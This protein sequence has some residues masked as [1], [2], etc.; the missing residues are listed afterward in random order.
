MPVDTNPYAFIPFFLDAESIRNF[1]GEFMRTPV[2]T[3][4]LPFWLYLVVFL[5]LQAYS[6]FK[7]EVRFVEVTI[8]GIFAFIAVQYNRATAIFMMM[9]I[10][11]VARWLTLLIDKLLTGKERLKSTFLPAVCG[12]MILLVLAWKF[13]PALSGQYKFSGGIDQRVYPVGSARFVNAVNPEGNLYNSQKFGA[14]LA[15]NLSPDNKIF[16]YNLPAIF[17]DMYSFVH[18]PNEREGWNINYAIVGE[19]IET[20]RVFTPNNWAPVYWEPNA[21]VLLKRTPEN[22]KLLQEYEL[23]LFMPHITEQQF[24]SHYLN[25]FA[26]RRLAKETSVY[27]SFR[28]DYRMSRL[29]S[30]LIVRPGLGLSKSGRLAMVLSA[31][32]YNQESLELQGAL[33]KIKGN[34]NRS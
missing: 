14:Y 26:A 6:I 31:L 9:S 5:A 10:P 3:F 21:I 2:N 23:H 17:R 30:E 19:R 32:K 12:V 24:R 11:F 22:L 28:E 4:F 16:H 7:K 8:L 20:E 15:Y 25:V 27:L 29:F 1:T 13:S 34:S 18:D 33:R